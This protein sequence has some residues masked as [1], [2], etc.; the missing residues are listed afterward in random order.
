VLRSPIHTRRGLNLN[1]LWLTGALGLGLLGSQGS[2]AQSAALPNPARAAAPGPAPPQAGAELRFDIFE[3]VVEGDTVLGAEAIERAVYPFLGPDRTVADA[4]GARKALEKAYQDAG[5]LSVNVLLPPQAVGAGNT[6]VRLQVVQATV[7]RLRVT[8]AQFSLPSAVREGM[9][10]LAAGSV[11]NFNEMQAELGRLA[12]AN[13]DREIT[14]LIAAG[15][16]PGTMSAELKL[17]DGLPLHGSVELN[18]KRKQNSVEGRLDAS[19]SYSNLFQRGHALGLSWTV[20]PTRRDDEDIR[21]L[22]YSLPLGEGSGRVLASY[23]HSRSKTA[24]PL[25]GSTVSPGDTWALQWRSAWAGRA[26]FTHTLSTGLTSRHLR[27]QNVDVAGDS[28]ASPSLRYTSLQAAYEFTSLGE[29][30]GRETQFRAG[31]SLGVPVFTQREVDCFGTA[32]DQFACKR[33]AASNKFQ[34]WSLTASHREPLGGWEL[35]GQLQAQF[36]DEPLVAPEQAVY[37]GQN[38]VRGYFEGEQ[39]GDAGAAL[40]F[41]L[42]APYWAATQGVTVRGFAFHDR[43]VLRRWYALPGEVAQV[44]MASAGLGLRVESRPSWSAQLGW[45]R[46]LNDTAR[47]DST[48]GQQPVSGA[49]AGRGDRWDLLLRYAF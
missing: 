7:E 28:S 6:E 18:N 42:L 29:V 17:Q 35:F 47:L 30:A 34:V 31:L 14:P 19:I 37:G 22:T 10:S 41:E 20:A 25:G 8:G 9:P 38:S 5:F 12:A 27:D 11:P 32:K 2:L 39:A 26:G 46:V 4:E 13:A 48:S 33:A 24:T 15:N 45:A 23:T 3:F 21:V 40:R 1:P 43:A 49:A 36:S 44:R 16:Q